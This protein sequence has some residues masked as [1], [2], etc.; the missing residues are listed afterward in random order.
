MIE[1]PTIQDILSRTLDQLDAASNAVAEAEAWL[2]SDWDPAGSALTDEQST[3][4]TAG[5]REIGTA[6]AAI[7]RAMDALDK[8]L[9]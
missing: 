7:D 5:L 9:P 6:K 3:A 4:K 8:A 2:L 1:M